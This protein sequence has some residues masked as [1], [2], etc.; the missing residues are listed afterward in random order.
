MK[1]GIL[2]DKCFLEHECGAYSHPERP[3]RLP[4]AIEGCK[5][6]G[7]WDDAKRVEARRATSEELRLAHTPEYVENV[8]EVLD[9]GGYGNLDPDTFFSPGSAEAARKAA[10]GGLDLAMAVHNREIEWGLALVRPPGHHATWHRPMGF[11]I[12]NNVVIAARSLIERGL[13][14]RVAIF[15]WDVHHGN[16]TQD[17]CWDDENIL[18]ASV[19]QWPFYPG[20]GQLSE[21]GGEAAR[22]STVNIPF[23]GGANDDDYLIA[24]D[25]VILPIL[26]AYRPEHIFVSAGFDAHQDDPLAGMGVSSPCYGQMASRLKSAAERLC[27]G[28]M[29]LFLEGGYSLEA[30]EESMGEVV[31]AMT[32]DIVP[33]TP[34]REGSSRPQR[35]VLLEAISELRPLWPGAFEPS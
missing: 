31:R 21:L 29:T 6:G 23:A 2:Y 13:A 30:L 18:Y 28:R 10:G 5:S 33:T 12:F 15:D 19:H 32:T 11:C 24:M 17:Q 16:G 1:P 26:E 27:G 7:I 34:S 9:R 25:D 8:L 4:A 3:E 14:K 20:T 35:R 22:G